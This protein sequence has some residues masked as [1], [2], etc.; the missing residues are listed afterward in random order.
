MMTGNKRTVAEWIDRIAVQFE[1][2][3]LHYGHGT[4]NAR[5]EAAWLVLHV[6]GAP[7]DGTFQDWGR[8]IGAAAAGTIQRLAEAR[9][10]GGA[11]LAYLTGQAWFAGLEFEVTPDVLVP[12]SPLHWQRLHRYRHRIAAAAGACG[13]QRYQR[14]G[15]RGCRA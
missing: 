1:A 9:C 5:D 6:L 13:C 12:R 14:R 4:D 15:A 3:G 7:L 11:P 10:S 2:A 8:G